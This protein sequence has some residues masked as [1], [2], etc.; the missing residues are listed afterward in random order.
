MSRSR[1]QPQ[2]PAVLFPAAAATLT[3]QGHS[4]RVPPRTEADRIGK[5]IGSTILSIREMIEAAG[6]VER[7][8]LTVVS[9]DPQDQPFPAAEVVPP[10]ASAPVQPVL[11]IPHVLWCRSGQQ[12]STPLSWPLPTLPVAVL[13]HPAAA[14]LPEP[15]EPPA[16]HRILAGWRDW[17][18]WT[19]APPRLP[20]RQR[21]SPKDGAGDAAGQSA[22]QGG[23]AEPGPRSEAAGG[24]ASV[25]PEQSDGP[26][27]S[28]P[29]SSAAPFD[30]PL[31]VAIEVE[32]LLHD[33]PHL[34]N[35]LREMVQEELQ[36][37]M[38]QRFSANLRAVIR[39]EITQ[40]LDDRLTHL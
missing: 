32:A 22:I 40:A 6:A 38:G 5:E 2:R 27:V 3:E 16:L 24:G 39:R 7:P 31:R 28:A 29:A 21:R 10:R 23:P 30:L 9:R 33:D 15:A 4:A 36:G 1:R 26:G 20:L 17:L 25:Q 34:R 14:V 12:A 8:R 13:P 35:G 11:P 19:L 18:L 37:E